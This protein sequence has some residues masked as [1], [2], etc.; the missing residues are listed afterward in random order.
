MPF[1]KVILKHNN[2]VDISK[3]KFLGGK[4]HYQ[5]KSIEEPVVRTQEEVNRV[6]KHLSQIHI[7]KRRP[8]TLKL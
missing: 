3:R 6:A 1:S 5:Q 2:K 8:I 4:L 7:N